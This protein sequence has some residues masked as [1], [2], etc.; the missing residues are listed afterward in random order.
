MD[1]LVPLE[2][3]PPGRPP[4]VRRREQLYHPEVAIIDEADAGRIL[5]LHWTL[6]VHRRSG[7]RYARETGLHG[8]MLHRFILG[9]PRTPGVNDKVDHIDGD[10]LNCRRS[11]LRVVTNIQNIVNSAARGGS[12][13]YKGVSWDKKRGVWTMQVSSSYATE[14]EAAA[15]YNMVASA[16]WGAHARLNG[17]EAG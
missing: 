10:G 11:N 6:H 7:V 3:N 5:A 13:H 16:L 1:A 17:L 4:T 15:A 14:D 2:K 9:L 12:S 8:I